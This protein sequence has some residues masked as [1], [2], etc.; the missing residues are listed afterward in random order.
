M[1]YPVL[2]LLILFPLLAGMGLLFVRRD[3]TVRIYTFGV[4]VL[5]VI[6]AFPLL[7]FDAGHTGFQF[8]NR[9]SWV[10]AWGLEYH[11]GV[12][13]ISLLMVALTLILF[14]LCV[15]CS[16][17][18]IEK[19]VR[20]FHLALIL[21]CAACVGVFSAL[22]FLLFYLF[23]EAVLIPMYLIIAI[24][25]GSERDTAS[26][27]FI[28]YTLAG[29]VLLLVA[30]IAFGVGCGTFSIPE[31]MSQK[32]SVSFQRWTF[33]VMA[34][35]FAVKIPMFPFHSWLPA[36]Y[37]Q[38]P[39]AGSVLLS[40][41]LAKMGAYGFLRFA[42]PL[43]PEASITFAPLMIAL[44]IASILYGGLMALGERHIKK[45][46]AYSS[47][48][49]MGF[50]TLGIFLLNFQGAQGAVLQM[51]NHGVTSG[52]LFMLAGALYARTHSYEVTDNQGLGKILPAFMGFWGLAAFSGFAFP[53][54]NNFVGEFLI[55]TG[56]FKKSLLI[57]FLMVPGALLAATYFLRVTQHMAW[58]NPRRAEALTDLTLREWGYLLPLAFLIIYL[59]LAP[60]MCLS[61]LEGL[62]P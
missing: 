51:V 25:G 48:A 40:C 27:R 37:S 11:V 61:I 44:S 52:I 41:V 7:G 55:F 17:T 36:A 10:P 5:E 13:G 21:L 29:S 9:L 16:W 20:S 42:L 54:T 1:T 28:L 38:A 6:L 32:F 47:M 49:H 62:A 15:L 39:I 59:G 53:G 56:A 24:W 26:L 23:Y 8:V 19:R 58:G 4:F 57:G 22:D 30:V 45:L 33:L 31:L 2:T 35:A 60:G 18:A 43:T 3:R 14:P 34:L 46:I 50:V 12:D